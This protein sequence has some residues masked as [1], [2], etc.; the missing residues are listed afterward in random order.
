MYCVREQVRFSGVDPDTAGADDVR[1][2]LRQLAEKP[3]S[4]SFFNQTVW[5][6]RFFSGKVLRG[7]WSVERIP[8]QRRGRRLPEILG[9]D[10]VP[11]L[12]A[13]AR[14]LG[15]RALFETAYGCGLRLGEIRHLKITDIDSGRMVLRVEQGK[16]RKDRYVMLPHAL[17]ETLRAYWRE[18]KPRYWLFPGQVPGQ[19]LSDKTVQMAVRKALRVAGITKRVSV[20]SLRHSFA[21]HL[22]EA[23]TNVRAIQVLLGHRSLGTTQL[24]THLA[25]TYLHETKSPLDRLPTQEKPTH[26]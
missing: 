23:G 2:Y 12:L 21:T 22:L 14:S 10:E 6:L 1:R 19:P 24:Y 13:A 7:E 3:V 8:F 17:L 4:W 5:A 25:A 26:T 9:T 11:R 15:D 18:A 16:G 20:H